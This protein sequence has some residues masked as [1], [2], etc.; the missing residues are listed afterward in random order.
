[1]SERRF[2]YE[3]AVRAQPLNYDAWF[4]Y[5][6][7]EEGAGDVEATRGVR[8]REMGCCM[9]ALACQP[10]SGSRP[11]ARIPPTQVY[12]RA[13]ANVPPAPE[14]RYW[15]RY[16]YLWLKY[17]LWEELE[18]GEWCFP[19]VVCVCVCACAAVAFLLCVVVVAGR[20]GGRAAGRLASSGPARG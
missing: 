1:M 6:R 13:I 19:C 3:E 4:D 12:E 20:Q 11:H 18:A 5:L 7:L 16:I 15:Q 17:A 14:K 2:Q 10:K 9:L 8:S